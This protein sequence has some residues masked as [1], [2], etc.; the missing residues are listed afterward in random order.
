MRMYHLVT[1]LVGSVVQSR[2]PKTRRGF[3]FVE[4]LTAMAVLALLAAIA[5]PQYRGMK[6][7]GYMASLKTQLGELRV[8]EES[9]FAEEQRYSTN[10]ADLDW[11]PSTQIAIAIASSNPAAGWR[12]E[13]THAELPGIACRTYVGAEVAGQVASGEIVCVSATTPAIPL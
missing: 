6:Q 4:L 1:S 11:K 9:W 2:H 10:I 5:V 13:A 8:A 12:A 3:T 7:R